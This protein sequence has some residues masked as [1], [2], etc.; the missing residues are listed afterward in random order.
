MNTKPNKCLLLQPSSRYTDPRVIEIVPKIKSLF[1]DKY[2]RPRKK[3]YYIGQLQVLLEKEA[4]PWIVYNATMLLCQ[5]EYLIKCPA[6]TKYAREAVFLHHS[7]WA[8]KEIE[9]RIRGIIKIIDR[10]SHPR[11]T[12]VLGRHLEALVKAELRAQ[13]FIITG[14]NTNEHQGKKW[15]K[16]GHNLDFIAEHKSGELKIGVEVKNTLSVPEREEVEIKIDICHYLG[17]APVFATRWIQPYIEILDD[18][19]GFGWIFK[20]QIYPLGFDNLT[21]T[22]WKRLG[23]PVNVRTDLPEK[24]VK[25]FTNWVTKKT[26]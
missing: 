8:R 25:I 23:L 12:R 21:K 22:I 20:T 18:S 16:T 5:Q 19:G 10:Y 3:P 9:P 15:K 14:A 26:V 7:R 11:V 13:G 17:L 1:E 6:P 4:Y 24:N 2:H